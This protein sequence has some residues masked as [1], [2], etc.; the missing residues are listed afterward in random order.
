MSNIGESQPKNNK[1]SQDQKGYSKPLNEEES[2]YKKII[3]KTLKKEILDQIDR[4][5]KKY[6]GL[7]EHMIYKIMK[8]HEFKDKLVETELAF[9]SG[10][11]VFRK[12][13]NWVGH[14]EEK[15]KNKNISKKTGQLNK[16]Q[17]K[18]NKNHKIK[19]N[20]QDHEGYYQK[21]D[22]NEYHNDFNYKHQKYPKNNYLPQISEK[23]Y[24]NDNYIQKNNR[25]S[26]NNAQNGQYINKQNFNNKYYYNKS[27]NTKNYDNT[28]KDNEEENLYVKKVEHIENQNVVIN[29]QES[30]IKND[31]NKEVILE[32]SPKEIVKKN[33][34]NYF[35]CSDSEEEEEHD[36]KEALDH[37]EEKE[38]VKPLEA[39]DENEKERT[40][41]NDESN[42]E[43]EEEKKLYNFSIGL[44]KI[45]NTLKKKVRNNF[46][47]LK[48]FIK[49]SDKKDF[50]KKMDSKPKKKY[51]DLGKT[52]DLEIDETSS[53]FKNNKIDLLIKKPF[54]SE[55]EQLKHNYEKKVD[56]KIDQKLD[57]IYNVMAKMQN[58]INFL[59]NK[60]LEY[61]KNENVPKNDIDPNVYCLVP[62]HLVK[63]LF[64]SSHHG[65]EENEK[66][67]TYYLKNKST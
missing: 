58:Q 63:N 2:N 41:E 21:N 66:L 16:G 52:F 62:F 27:Q 54:Q 3:K 30:K 42:E 43:S 4:F 23:Y 64:S 19:N 65:S 53:Y 32:E 50:T 46:T 14:E 56:P 9:Q 7:K 17:K 5:K 6:L 1:I 38:Q 48:D 28:R 12:S 15:E 45:S 22:N 36:E 59:Q 55:E 20:Y 13:D 8:K 29:H 35:F 26:K 57:E 60:L 39:F 37:S 34:K 47:Y 31:K 49:I 11:Q 33:S 10:N 25:F 51:I 67:Q 44:N 18:N 40:N 61:Q 24:Y